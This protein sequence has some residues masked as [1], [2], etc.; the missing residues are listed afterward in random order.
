[1]AELEP[2][3]E[4]DGISD[5]S[6]HID[7]SI[8]NEPATRHWINIF[9]QS[10]VPLV[11][12][13]TSLHI[14]WLNSRFSSLFKIKADFVGL[15]FDKYFFSSETSG[16]Q[17][18]HLRHAIRSPKMSYFWQGKVEKKSVDGVSIVLNLIILPIFKNMEEIR[19][20]IAYACICDNISDEYKQ[21]LKITFLSLLEASRLKDNDTGNHIQRVNLYSQFL[22]EKLYGDP[23]YEEVDRGF[24]E[25]IGFLAA[26]HDV[27]KI[28]T[29]DDILNKPG[30]LEPF[31]W[32]I[33]REHTI[34]GAF[35]LNTYPNPMAKEIAL[36]HHEWW[37]GTGYPYGIEGE[38]IPLSARV[39]AIADVYDALR[40]KRSYKEAFS[41]V[42]AVDI[43]LS[44]KGEH[45]EPH[46]VDLFLKYEQEFMKI[47]ND[48]RD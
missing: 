8:L 15:S 5:Y 40:M 7:I 31:Q 46:L 48:L 3:T 6:N 12:L 43:I 20:P 22:A 41:H 9:S 32:E 26:M 37:D 14:I 36:H 38:M 39:V 2:I 13:D 33:M 35:L 28:G 25:D 21:I 1:M 44:A 4:F 34:N 30:P 29:P 16:Q 42:D 10:P 18:E 11:I 27:G 24:I 23:L 47:F 45:F 19:E 17:L